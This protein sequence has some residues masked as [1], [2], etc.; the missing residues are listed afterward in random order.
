MPDLDLK[1]AEYR[2]AGRPR[3]IPRRDAYF[4]LAYAVAGTLFLQWLVTSGT[5]GQWWNGFLM[6]PGLIMVGVLVTRLWPYFALAEDETNP[7]DHPEQ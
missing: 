5:P 7:N 6:W 3:I 4:L 1:P 2:R